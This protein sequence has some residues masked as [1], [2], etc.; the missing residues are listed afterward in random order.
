MKN[1]AVYYIVL[2]V[3]M[4]GELVAVW[5]TMP[6]QNVSEP[7]PPPVGEAPAGD[8]FDATL[9][10]FQKA[11]RPPEQ[12]TFPDA[13]RHLRLFIPKAH[14]GE[15]QAGLWPDAMIQECLEKNVVLL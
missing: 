10:R 15:I 11:W 12:E 4:V 5:L 13:G 2:D 1:K 14:V 9:D 3:L 6:E 8:Q 7:P